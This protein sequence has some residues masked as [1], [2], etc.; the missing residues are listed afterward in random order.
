[1]D[2]F[3]EQIVTGLSIGSI[4]LLVALGLSIIYGSMGIINLA[5]GEFVM[6]GAYAAWV[7]HTYLGLG[8]LASLVPIF[9]VVAAFGWIIERFVLSL[10]NN[11]PL[12]T[13]LATWGVGIMLQ[14]AVRLSV[15]SELRYVQLP[16]ALSDS[17]NVF[18]IPI[19]SYRVFLF[20]VSIALFGATWLLM[21]RTTVGMKLRAIIQ[22]R[23]VAASFGINAKRVYALTFAYGAGLAGLAGALVSPLKSV[24]PDMGTG[25]VVDAFMVVVLGGVQSLAGTVASAFILGELSGGIAFLQNDTVAKAIVLLAIVVLIRFRPEGL[26]TARVRA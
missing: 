7:F 6:L 16:P 24:S 3:I 11:R 22:D 14:Q 17:M 1:M 9:L 10:L 18:G 15:G 4:L 8:L 5:H 26:F 19:S 13:I 25:Y 12:D 21:N 20:V 23:S 2:Q